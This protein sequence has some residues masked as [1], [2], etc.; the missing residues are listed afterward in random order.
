MTTGPRHSLRSPAVPLEVPVTGLRAHGRDVAPWGSSRWFIVAVVAFGLALVSLGVWVTTG[1]GQ[2]EDQVQVAEVERGVAVEQRDATA[3]QAQRAA[4]PVLQLCAQGDEVAQA[5]NE[6]GACGLAQQVATTPVPPVA[7]PTGATGATGVPGP[8][9]T[10]EAISA[11]VAAYMAANPPAQG[12]PGRPPTPAEVAA[13]VTN[14]LTANPPQPGRPPTA[15]EIADAVALYFAANPPP[16]GEPG[17]GPT[18]AEIQGA[19]DAHL[20]NN[21]PPRGE[22]GP[23]CPPGSTLRSVQFASGESGLGCVTAD[24]PPPPPPTTTPPPVEDPA[25]PENDG[26]LLGG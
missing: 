13:A 19:V 2:V 15:A 26:G 18:A 25:E 22:P 14:Y 1:A 7:G 16:R 17:R 10:A 23:T 5:L 6:R 12:E 24:A 11:A 20:A 3:E 21:P 8:P 9:P 4:D